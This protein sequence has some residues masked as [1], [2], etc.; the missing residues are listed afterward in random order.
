LKEEEIIKILSNLSEKLSE[1]KDHD[2]KIQLLIEFDSFLKENKE[3]I[4]K[5]CPDLLVSVLNSL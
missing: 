1:L 4:K 5:K 3:I 2:K